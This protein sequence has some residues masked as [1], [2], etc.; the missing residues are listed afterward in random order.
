MQAVESDNTKA[1]CKAC[2]VIV[3]CGKSELEKHASRVKHIKNV[4]SVQSNRT[5]VACFSKKSDKSIHIDKVKTAEIRLATFFAEHNVAFST[6]DHLV[7]VLKDVFPDS[8]IAS[9][10]TLGRTKCT[11][12]VKNVVAKV[13]TDK[14]VQTLKGV[15]FSILVDE[16]TDISDSKNMCVIVRYVSPVDGRVKTQLLELIPLDAKD[17]SAEKLFIALGK[18]VEREGY[19]N[20]KCYWHGL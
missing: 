7:P 11:N 17:C 12:I 4:K 9:D 20:Y 15:K 1:R 3:T 2:N 18:Y 6:V 13:E 5:V 19:S 16:S 14:T 10:V 8:K